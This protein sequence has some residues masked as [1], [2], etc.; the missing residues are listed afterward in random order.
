[1]NAVNNLKMKT[2]PEKFKSVLVNKPDNYLFPF[3]WVHN[4]DDELLIREI[5]KIYQSGIRALCIE[6]RTHEEFGNAAW[7]S[8]VQLIL[9]EC[10][11]RGME[12]WLL[13]DKHFPTGGANGMASAPENAHLRKH[14]IT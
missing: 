13:D 14:I 10:K 5:E 7:W 6:S 3:L 2:F 11:K 12:V 8:D 4:E 1:M 9:D